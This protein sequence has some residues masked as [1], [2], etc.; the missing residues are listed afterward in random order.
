MS[1]DTCAQLGELQEFSYSCNTPNLGAWRG[2]EPEQ[3]FRV[4]VSGQYWWSMDSWTGSSWRSFPALVILWFYRLVS[5][6]WV[7]IYFWIRL[8]RNF[9]TAQ[10]KFVARKD[11]TVFNGNCLLEI[12]CALCVKIPQSLLEITG[13]VVCFFDRNF[14]HWFGCPGQS[15]A[16]PPGYLSLLIGWVAESHQMHFPCGHL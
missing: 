4:T 3:N 7:E 11:K 1:S 5:H 15:R 13:G 10:R 2:R 12:L 9:K 14:I 6:P 8:F 16:S